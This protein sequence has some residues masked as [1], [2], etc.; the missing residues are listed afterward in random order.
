[1][2]NKK[3]ENAYERGQI[4]RILQVKEMKSATEK[5]HLRELNA[6][7]SHPKK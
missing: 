3:K 7:H 5:Y 1:M 4:N 6:W 2:N